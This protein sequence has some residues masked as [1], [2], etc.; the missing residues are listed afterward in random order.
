MITDNNHL[1]G[2]PDFAPSHWKEH[3]QIY[4]LTQKMRSQKD[5]NFSSICDRVGRGEINDEDEQFLQSR[6]LSTESEKENETSKMAAFLL[7]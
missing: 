3:F 5:P 1:D 7:S 2:R 6:I 4:Y